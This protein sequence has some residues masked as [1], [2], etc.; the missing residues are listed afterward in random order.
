[1]ATGFKRPLILH[2]VRQLK[3][4]DLRICNHFAHLRLYLRGG[5]GGGGGLVS[6]AAV[7]WTN[8]MVSCATSPHLPCRR[9]EMGSP[10]K[11]KQR[12]QP[13]LTQVLAAR[14]RHVL[15]GSRW[16]SPVQGYCFW[17]TDVGG[18]RVFSPLPYLSGTARSALIRMN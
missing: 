16:V 1:M 2:C 11:N 13:G 14:T 3:T 18:M 9:L 7:M 5:A 17:C 8:W 15:S 6:G 4:A 10:G 12:M